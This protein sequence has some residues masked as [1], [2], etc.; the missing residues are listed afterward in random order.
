MSDAKRR[1]LF[2]DTASPRVNQTPSIPTLTRAPRRPWN[3]VVGEIVKKFSPDY[4]EAVRD[5]QAIHTHRSMSALNVVSMLRER[6]LRERLSITTTRERMGSSTPETKAAEA[7]ILRREVDLKLAEL[8]TNDVEREYV[9][10]GL[11]SSR[12]DL[13]SREAD[14]SWYDSQIEA[15]ARVSPLA[16]QMR[17][18]HARPTFGDLVTARK[19]VSP[20]EPSA[21]SATTTPKVARPSHLSRFPELQ[22]VT[23]DRSASSD[24]SATS[25]TT[26]REYD[27]W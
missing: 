3:G 4:Q 13:P 7:E 18:D 25:T 21:P 23:L 27:T 2:V 6:E 9:E 16:A 8:G 14:E 15:M 26:E 24:A 17:S 11:L 12:R 5:E 19:K 1:E 10:H 22:G 20:P